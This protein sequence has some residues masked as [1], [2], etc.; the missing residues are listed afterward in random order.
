[1]S[2][3][4]ECDADHKFLLLQAWSSACMK[5]T[6]A[7]NLKI[8]SVAELASYPLGE[9]GDAMWS[10][11][12]PM[13]M[14]STSQPARQLARKPLRAMHRTSRCFR[15]MHSPKDNR[16]WPARRQAPSHLI[17]QTEQYRSSTPQNDGSR[18][19]LRFRALKKARK[20]AVAGADHPIRNRP[21]ASTS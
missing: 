17:F 1:M 13:G 9:F 21:R 5:S 11:H 12:S 6:I 7:S 4:V 19:R 10:G 18:P 15:M 14:C 3:L 8:R 16:P 20:I 2:W